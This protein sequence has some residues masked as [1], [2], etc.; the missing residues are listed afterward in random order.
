MTVT[1]PKIRK[2]RGKQIRVAKTTERLPKQLRT[3]KYEISFLVPCASVYICFRCPLFSAE[4]ISSLSFIPFFITFSLL[5]R[6]SQSASGCF[7]FGRSQ[8]SAASVDRSVAGQPCGAAR[9]S[10]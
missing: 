2:F 7:R 9:A 10:N 1:S 5:H 3:G 8:L 6:H 4:A